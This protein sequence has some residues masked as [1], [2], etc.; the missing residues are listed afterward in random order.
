MCREMCVGGRIVHAGL[1]RSHELAVPGT[2][3]RGLHHGGIESV[4]P[5]WTEA[6]RQAV[7]SQRHSWPKRRTRDKSWLLL[8]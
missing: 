7:A 5:V 1:G 4:K 3:G 8:G 6:M 2:G